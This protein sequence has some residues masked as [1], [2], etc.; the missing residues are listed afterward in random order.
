MSDE[1]MREQGMT[2]AERQAQHDQMV[3]G[4]QN[5]IDQWK[6]HLVLPEYV[7]KVSDAEVLGMLVSKWTDWTPDTVLEVAS[8]AAEDSNMHEIATVIEDWRKE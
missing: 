7:D 2:I 3:G 1:T 5:V 6:S 4:L 8:A